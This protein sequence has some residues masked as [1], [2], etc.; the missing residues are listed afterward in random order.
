MMKN[1]SDVRHIFRGFYNMVST[2]FDRKIK[3]FRPDNA[4]KLAFTDY[5][6]QTGIQHQFSCVG[7]PKQN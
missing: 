4:Q 3:V 5:F 6:S 2:Q 7:C 1:K